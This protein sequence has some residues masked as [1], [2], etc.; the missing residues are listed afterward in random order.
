MEKGD[1]LGLALMA[2]SGAAATV[3]CWKLAAMHSHGNPL[4]W[5]LIF[6]ASA[7]VVGPLCWGL[8]MAISLP[9]IKD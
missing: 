2:A 3:I 1:K 4:L 8:A 5:M 7:C 9:F 6:V